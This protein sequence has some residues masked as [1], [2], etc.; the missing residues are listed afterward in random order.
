[1]QP[2][3]SPSTRSGALLDPLQEALEI[4]ERERHAGSSALPRWQPDV[5]L[6]E[7]D[8]TLVI[9]AALP[10]TR[11]EDV[12]VR[13][14]GDL[15]TLEA[16]RRSGGRQGRGFVRSFLLPVAVRPEA[17]EA[18]LKDGILTVT[19]DKLRQLRSRRIP[20]A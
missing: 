1:V 5:W 6:D 11:G 16:E 13:V 17:V 9:R 2:A 3:E 10:G 8:A 12:R 19:V 15:L 14:A 4:L 20:L 7:N 18:V